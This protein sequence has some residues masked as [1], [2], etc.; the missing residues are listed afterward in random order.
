MFLS[1]TLDNKFLWI[2]WMILPPPL[3]Q[4]TVYGYTCMCLFLGWSWWC[5]KNGSITLSTFYQ[6]PHVLPTSVLSSREKVFREVCWL[7]LS[8]NLKIQCIWN[9]KTIHWYLHCMHLNTAQVTVSSSFEDYLYLY[10][11]SFTEKLCIITCSRPNWVL[12]YLIFVERSIRRVY[13]NRFSSAFYLN[14]G[15]SMSTNKCVKSQ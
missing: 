6:K 2:V 9:W 5:G 7:F 1:L 3:W 10:F 13:L 4:V 15:Q 14:C 12:P 11:L 8:M